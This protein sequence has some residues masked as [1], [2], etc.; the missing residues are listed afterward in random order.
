MTA[1]NKWL[2]A[3]V[4]LIAL[5]AAGIG[6]ANPTSHFIGLGIM[7]SVSLLGLIVAVV[8]ARS[9]PSIPLGPVGMLLLLFWGWG[10]LA[11]LWSQVPD[12]TVL[13]MIKFGAIVAAY[14]SWRIVMAPQGRHIAPMLYGLLIVAG[15][16]M[17]VGMIGQAF[18]GHRA[19]ALFLNPNS[20]A[21]LLNVI[22][23]AA[24][25]AWL[26]GTDRM[27]DLSR[28]QRFMPGVLF[29]LVFAAGLDGGRASFLALF[30]ALIVVVGGAAYALQTRW[31]RL[32]GV[33]G[34]VIGALVLAYL[35]NLFGLTEGRPLA[36]RVASLADP[37]EA[38]QVRF[39]MWSATWDMIQENPWLG[40]GPGVF[41]LAYAAVRPAGDG[42]AGQYA[43]ND[44]LQFWVERGLPGLL[45]VIALIA[46]CTWLFFRSVRAGRARQRTPAERGAV[47]AAFAAIGG[48]GFHGLF[49]Y[50]LQ[51]PA[52]MIPVALLLAELE[53]MNGD[54]LA[55]NVPMPAWRRP[56]IFASA[57]G[58]VAS[59]L[60][61][62]FLIASSQYYVERGQE[63]LRDGEIFAAEQSFSKAMT[64]WSMTDVP[65]L[66][67]ALLYVRVS[68]NL[69]EDRIWGGE[70]VFSEAQRFLDEAE[71]RNS[72]R[73][74][75]ARLRAKL[76]LTENSSSGTEIAQAFDAALSRN[77]RD[78]GARLS[79]I[80][81]LE[82]KGEDA[83]AQG[84]LE[85]GID[86]EYSRFSSGM[87]FYQ[88]VST[89]FSDYLTPY[90]KINAE[91]KLE[92]IKR[93]IGGEISFEASR[94]E[95][96]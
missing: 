27:L 29:L 81:F 76:F 12:Q 80:G 54:T 44:Y 48:I 8:H 64:R 65:W 82:N 9:Q 24:A 89:D 96:N 70:T 41:W 61:G 50:Q 26:V 58:L 72:L 19:Q 62:L 59:V 84:I 75:P 22:W 5:T 35:A 14:L 1:P 21:A 13:Q 17:A 33:A 92:K 90:S 46:V 45:I 68:E 94:L 31:R 74:T 73:S 88:A 91:S 7:G 32:A 83:K 11:V 15:L 77:P 69:S 37:S 18:T 86:L 63:Q 10:A 51:L 20:A 49:S 23:P 71:R 4:V 6:Q 39:L 55:V 28:L 16:I 3:A 53:R 87:R 2:P 34:L 79:Y 42:S 56:L 38:G 43:H 60:L 47:I 57:S 67:K 52:V 95:I 85:K 40:I 36:D 66:V 93:E 30:T 25:V 78:V